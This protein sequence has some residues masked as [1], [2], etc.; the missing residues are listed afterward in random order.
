MNI[1]HI[2]FN[3]EKLS[4]HGSMLVELLM[5]I[6]LAAIIMPFIF[7][8]QQTVTQRAENI[9]ITRQMSDIQDALERYI[10]DHRQNL[11]SAVGRNITRVNISE[12]VP[13]GVSADLT[14]AGDMYQL[15]VLKSNDS[16]GRAT[17]QGVIVFSSDEI[18]PMRTRE[19]V[20]LGGDNMGFLDGTRAYG[21]FGSWH[22]DAIDLGISSS[23]GIIET[24]SVNTDNTLYLWRLPSDDASDATMLSGLN[25]GGHNISNAKFFDASSAQFN[26]NLN[27]GVS[28]ADDVIFQTR[29]T[30]DK[31]LEVLNVSVAGTFTADSR[32]IEVADTFN[33]ADTG[34]FSN[35]TTGDLYTANLT[36]GGLSVSSDETGPI[37]LN[38]NRTL[39]MTGGTISAMFVTVGFAGSVAPRLI[40]RNRIEDSV[41][42]NYFWDASTGVMNFMDITLQELNR[43]AQDITYAE[44]ATNTVA[45]EKFSAVVA[46]KNATVSDYINAIQEIQTSVRAKYRM[47]NLE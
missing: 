40:V 36:L 46:N 5:S 44:R 18:S 28:V 21:T 17:L 39:D 20:S 37:V 38:I 19:I 7:Q 33:L 15:R 3:H 43:M 12:L 34:K 42:P 45:Y 8:Y 14:D 4:Q 11:L 1:I 41:N 13:Y 16:N 30:L 10:M 25:L 23:G 22:A 31:A 9:A 24:T 35:F 26:E 32:E 27:V 6:A 2:P 29:T 47:L